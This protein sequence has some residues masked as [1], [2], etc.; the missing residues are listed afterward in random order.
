MKPIIALDMGGTSVKA[1]VYHWT[2]RLKETSWQHNYRDCRLEEAKKDLVSRVR[3]FNHFKIDAVGISIAGLLAKD[4]SLYKSTV[5]TS[6]QGFN[7]PQF[8][9]QELDAGIV[10]IDNDADCGAFAE[11]DR[12]GGE[13]L[14][15]IIGSGIGSAYVDEKGNLPYLRRFDPKH[16]FSDTDNPIPNDLGLQVAV[17][18]LYVCEKFNVS[19]DV[20]DN[21]LV[22]KDGSPL[23][24]PSGDID[25]I[26]L[27]KICSAVGI[28]NII[29]IL[30][31][32][33]DVEGYYREYYQNLIKNYPGYPF[34]IKDEG[35]K[36]LADERRAA[37]MLSF[38]ADRGEHYACRAFELF[39]HFLGYGIVEALKFIRSDQN[40]KDFP[41]LYLSGPIMSS[42][43][44]FEDSMS[45]VFRETGV[46]G[47]RKFSKH[48]YPNL[49]GAYLRAFVKFREFS[50]DPRLMS[51]L[52]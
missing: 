6:F 33:K 7:I 1:G 14:Y 22:D 23:K 30:L 12:S 40:L 43:T 5:L 19:R 49:Y 18:K 50:K 37:E 52:N 25:S 31:F 46:R 51:S 27:E 39:G 20:L 3:D 13:L 10:T 38:F 35:F 4:G 8:L 42:C 26:R 2:D 28:K 11:F 44:L 47:A 32:N 34:N 45:E 24:G 21:V 41:P 9:R 17:P 36:D 48:K 16:K 29:D 15:V